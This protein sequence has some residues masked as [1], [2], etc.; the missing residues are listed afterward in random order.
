VSGVLLTS[1]E[2]LYHLPCESSARKLDRFGDGWLAPETAVRTDRVVVAPPTFRHDLRFLERVEQLAVEKLRPHLC[3]VI[4]SFRQASTTASPL[5]VSSSIVR[6]C[7]RISSGVYRFLDM[8]V[9]SLV[10]VQAN[11][12]PGPDWPGQVNRPL[13]LQAE[14]F[15]ISI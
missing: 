1:R 12:R 15:G 9:T 11:I 3:S 6:R 4:P 14:R 8:T 2:F 5:P 7:C 10:A 13:I